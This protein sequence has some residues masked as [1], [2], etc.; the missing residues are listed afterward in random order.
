MKEQRTDNVRLLAD[1]AEEADA[2]DP[3]VKR[4]AARLKAKESLIA[5]LAGGDFSNQQTRV[6]HILNLHPAARNSD[7]ALSLKYWETFQPELYN[8]EGIK[9]A[10]FFKLDRVPFLVRARAKI[11]NEYELFQ[12]EDPVRR[13]RKGR[14]NDMRDAVLGDDVPRQT[15]QVFSD[16]TGKTEEHVIIGS[17]WVLSGRAVYD[18]TKAIKDW[19]AGSKF[20]K[21][22]VHFSAFGRGDM[23]AVDDYL[24]TVAAN[25][26]FLSFKLMAMP[27]RNSRRSI[28]E[29]VQRLHE[30]M[31]VRGLRHE[32]ESGR[33]GMP[34]HVGVTVDEEQSIDRIVL[35]EIRNTVAEAVER[36]HLDGVTLD[37][38][39]NA[40]SSKESALIQLADVIAGATNRRLN[41]RGDRNFKDDIADR[42]M[43]VLGLQL[44]EGIAAE[45]DAAVLFKI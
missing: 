12:A 32:I 34:R 28:E 38:R 3:E 14:E 33:V 37:E 11:Q 7:V 44:E 39:F 5:S 18:V 40:V 13:R 26:E 27:K 6:A 23:N 29:I 1:T 30:M 19:Q 25:R 45:I 4:V 2:V 9:P 16:E 43:D 42:V 22:E 8:P 36:A 41:F 20:A 24:N 10:D 21:R 17:V 31:L 15:L 35:S